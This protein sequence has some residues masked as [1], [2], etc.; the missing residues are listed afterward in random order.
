MKLCL[1]L[2]TP[3]STSFIDKDAKYG[4][5]GDAFGSGNL[6]LTTTFSS[7]WASA[8][9]I[10]RIFESYKLTKLYPG[11]YFGT[12]LETH[13]R[14]KDIIQICEDVFSGS[15]KGQVN[16]QPTLGLDHIINRNGIRINFSESSLK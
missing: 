4:F 16:E 14:I 9:R 7:L 1:L 10:D 5:S 3:G 15:E 11:H 13:E 2:D 12:N 6:L 8:K